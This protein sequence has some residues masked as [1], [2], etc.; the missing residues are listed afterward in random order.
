MTDKPT[1]TAKRN[2]DGQPSLAPAFLL[3][4]AIMFLVSTLC[5]DVVIYIHGSLLQSQRRA[6]SHLQSQLSSLQSES[7]HQ[8]GESGQ[9]SDSVR[10]DQKQPH[11]P[12]PAISAAPI[13]HPCGAA[14]PPARTPQS[15]V[16]ESH[17]LP[18]A[19]YPVRASVSPESALVLPAVCHEMSLHPYQ[20]P[21]YLITMTLFMLS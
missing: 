13:I 18:S 17:H 15:L 9:L 20:A 14:M 19:I 16:V 11:Q 12:S 4:A 8:Y 3:G 10:T 6:I 1:S 21:N 2:C 5:Q 7:R